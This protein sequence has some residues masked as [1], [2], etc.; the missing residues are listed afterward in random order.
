M[1]V[2]GGVE[3][4][5]EEIID[6]VLVGFVVARLEIEALVRELGGELMPDLLDLGVVDHGAQPVGRHQ[7]RSWPVMALPGKSCR[8]S[9]VGAMT[10]AAR[11]SRRWRSSGP[12]LE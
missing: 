3:D 9:V 7:K 11:A 8:S 5:V 12:C 10:A 6:L 1:R 2:P 4:A